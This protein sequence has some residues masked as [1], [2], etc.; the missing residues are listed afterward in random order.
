TKA[1]R[2]HFSGIRFSILTT[3]LIAR[4]VL[5]LEYTWQDSWIVLSIFA[6]VIASYAMYILS[7]DKEV[8]QN[9]VKHKFDYSIFTF[10]VIL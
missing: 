6:I 4:N 5:I 7:V 3:D 9:V 10:F 1:M 2:I 8:K